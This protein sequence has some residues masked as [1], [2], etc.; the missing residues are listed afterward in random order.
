[1]AARAGAPRTAREPAEVLTNVLSQ[2]YRRVRWEHRE[3]CQLRERILRIE[4][5]LLTLSAC[6]GLELEEVPEPPPVPELERILA[7]EERPHRDE[8]RTGGTAHG[9]WTGSR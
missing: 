7:L 1:M 4:D 5:R 3:V 2:I 6:A 9:R 8:P